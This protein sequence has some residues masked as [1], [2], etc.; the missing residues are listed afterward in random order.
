MPIT[1]EQALA[2]VNP[3]LSDED[4]ESA[5]RAIEASVA[6]NDAYWDSRGPL[7]Q[8]MARA[9]GHGQVTAPPPDGEQSS[10]STGD[11]KPVIDTT[12]T[13]N[14]PPTLPPSSGASGGESD[15]DVAKLRAQI[16]SMGGTPEV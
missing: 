7:E 6:A 4:K 12:A 14:T 1:H 13:D 9:Q 10:V 3:N 2:V 8:V 15:D 16:E 5:A 11:D